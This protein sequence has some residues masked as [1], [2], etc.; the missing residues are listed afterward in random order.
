MDQTYR[1]GDDVHVLPSQL[2]VPG[3]GTIPINAFVLSSE[4]PGLVDCGLGTDAEAFVE[5]LGAVIDPADLEWIWLTHD[6]AD[7]TGSL[8]RILELAPAARIITHAFT[9]LRMNSAWAVPLDRVTAIAP[10]DRI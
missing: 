1:V 7:H 2:P 6:D 3:V 4:R 9:A 5:A 10:G 8:Q